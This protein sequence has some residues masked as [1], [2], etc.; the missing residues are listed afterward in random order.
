MT[1]SRAAALA[2]NSLQDGVV[3]AAAAE[4]RGGD[5]GNDTEDFRE[6]IPG[7]CRSYTDASLFGCFLGQIVLES[8]PRLSLWKDPRQVR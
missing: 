4:V 3:V 6:S 5:E 1:L 2:E 7:A 8:L